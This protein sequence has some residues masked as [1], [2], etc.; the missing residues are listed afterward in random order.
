MKV[1]VNVYYNPE[2]S[3]LKIFEDLDTAGSYE[4]DIFLILEDAL[5][6]LYYCSDS[7]CSCP[8]PFEDVTE[9]MEITKDTLYNFD[10]ALENHSGIGTSDYLRISKKV[11]DHLARF[12]AV[13]NAKEFFYS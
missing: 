7:G 5:G 3:G 2:L 9:V 1:T 8:T 10:K 4:F 11:K 6:M 13:N 12:T